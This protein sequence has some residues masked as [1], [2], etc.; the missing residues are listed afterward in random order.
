VRDLLTAARRGAGGTL[1]DISRPIVRMPGTKALLPALTELRRTRRHLAVVVDEYGGTDGIVTLEDLVE[2]LVG[3]IEDEYDTSTSQVPS[4]LT[5]AVVVDGLLHRTEV[6]EQT[7]LVLPDGPYETLGGFVVTTLG[8]VP[9][10]GD[11]VEA[12][13]HRLEVVEMDGRRAARIRVEPLAAPSGA[14][15]EETSRA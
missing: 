7:G 1:A 5:G 10:P 8:R 6:A 12:L 15:E 11:R 13:G 4:G 2:E 9:R 3:E 14:K